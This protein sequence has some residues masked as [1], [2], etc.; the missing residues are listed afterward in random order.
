MTAAPEVITEDRDTFADYFADEVSGT[1][2][3]YGRDA[4]PVGWGQA[5]DLARTLYDAGYRRTS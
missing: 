1:W 5:V 3:G 4:Q 2:I